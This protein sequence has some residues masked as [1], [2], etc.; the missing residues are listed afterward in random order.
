MYRHI[1]WKI[2]IV[3]NKVDIYLYQLYPLW[4]ITFVI[5]K[6]NVTG[7]HKYRKKMSWKEIYPP[8]PTPLYHYYGHSTLL[9][10]F[11]NKLNCSLCM[12]LLLTNVT[13]N[14][15]KRKKCGKLVLS[16]KFTHKNEMNMPCNVLGSRAQ[17]WIL[18]WL[19][20]K[21]YN[22]LMNKKCQMRIVY[23][24]FLFLCMV[25][26]VSGAATTKNSSNSRYKLNWFV[27]R[28]FPYSLFS[29]LPFLTL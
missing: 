23:S 2:T 3:Y 19:F 10:L 21:G 28:I 4:F 22:Y 8:Y 6:I 13:P 25:Y 18:P 11:R 14:I 5:R 20:H 24:T 29:P 17:R 12:P 9:L 27:V 26:A 7:I 16:E 15:L 1:L